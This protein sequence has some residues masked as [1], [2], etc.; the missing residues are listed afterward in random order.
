MTARAW[1][2]DVL[3]K[4]AAPLGVI[5]ARAILAAQALW[6]T[7]SYPYTPAL[8]HWPAAIWEMPAA[9]R[10]RFGILR[11]DGVVILEIALWIVLHI[12]L[13]A[14]LFGVASRVSC[15]TAAVLLYHFAP[16]EALAS[17]LVYVA[18]L[19]GLTLPMLGLMILGVAPSPKRDEAWSPDYRWPLVL[20]QLVFAF[21]YVNAGLAKLHWAH[22]QWWSAG[23]VGRL[24][25]LMTTF[26]SPPLARYVYDHPAL[27]G[28]IG[29]ATFALEFL[30]PLAIFAKW[31]RRIIIPAA[32]VAFVLRI[33]VLGFFFLSFPALLLFI[34]WDFVDGLRRRRR[35]DVDRAVVAEKAPAAVS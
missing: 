1:I 29:V 28:A 27:A 32:F 19:G 5:A 33:Y 11:F 13:I 18:S 35:I 9:M 17:G 10:L 31:A 6:I 25:G 21:H 26:Q 4:P 34:N 3:F 20:I 24:A 30:F 2:D 23:N 15:L 14:A 16:F 8:A 7:L 12:A 22:L